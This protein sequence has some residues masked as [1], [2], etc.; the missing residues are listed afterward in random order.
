VAN[1]PAPSA[2]HSG[3]SFGTFQNLGAIDEQARDEVSD[4]LAAP[5]IQTTDALKWWWKHRREYPILSQLALDY[6]SIPCTR[7]T[8]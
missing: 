3:I 4:Y 1:I 7:S 2:T 6:L 5:R 8:S